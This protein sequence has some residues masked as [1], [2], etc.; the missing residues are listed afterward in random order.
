MDK[1]QWQNKGAG[2]RARLRERFLEK[3]LIGFSDAEVI[4]LL[5]SF[6]TPRK[7]C[8]QAARDLLEQFT[9]FAAVLDAHPGDIQKIKG[10]GPKNAFALA[11][12]KS[13][14][15][16]YLK[17]RLRERSYLSSSK[18]VID[19]LTHAMRGLKVEVLTVIYLD[20][21]HGII[22]TETVA[23]GT[24]NATTIYPREIVKR[25][26][27]YD[28]VALVIA[29]NHPSGSST[30]SAQDYQLTRSLY[31]VCSLMNIRLLDHLI[32]G[33]D[34]HSFADQ[35][36]LSEISDWCQSVTHSSGLS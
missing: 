11:F 17:E 15:D 7:D 34:Y 1:A 16:R 4:E 3:G 21:A 10:I 9:S 30:P 6:G 31:L 35:G 36:T 24:I 26:L 20:A 32:I 33:E 12:I 5:L 14:A 29:H 25:A 13:A 23:E 19:Y 2:H 18:E 27:A 8:K 22:D 28:A